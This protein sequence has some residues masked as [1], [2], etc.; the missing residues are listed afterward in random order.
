[1]SALFE[2]AHAAV[3]LSSMYELRGTVT[4]VTGLV[5][6]GTGPSVAVGSHVSIHAGQSVHEAQ[7]VGFRGDRVLLMPFSE[8]QGIS[9]GA[10][11]TANGTSAEVLVSQHLLGRVIDS[12]GRPM[13]GRP[14]PITG[15]LVPL[16]R[17]PP[18]AVTRTRIHEVF[19]LGVRAMNTFL[20]MGTGQ[21]VGI[22][23]GSGVGKSTLLGM[24]A[25]HSQSD[26]N[27]IGLVGERGREVR[28]F[29]ERDLGPEGL[30]R[31][32]VVVATGNEPAL[33]RIRAAFLAT[34][35]A[36][37]FRDKGNKV[38]LMIDSI[39]RLAMA[40][41]EVG[42]A[43]GEPPSTR[44]YTPSVF[45][46]LPK[47]LERAGTC[48]GKGSITGIYTVLVEGDDMNE[49][50]ADATRG[51]LDGHVVLSRKLASKGHFPA[52]DILQS[53]SRVMSDVVS[54]EMKAVA[55]IGR[56]I[57]ATY[58]EAEDL[59]T[60]GAY[61]QGQ[62]PKVDRAVA[63]IDPLTALLRQNALDKC[64]MEDSWR[65]LAQ[66]MASSKQAAPPQQAEK[67]RSI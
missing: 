20:T 53:I 7:V 13:D 22:M 37:Y 62:N 45:A 4:D 6:E 59:I 66:V 63:L 34:A 19:D 14:L 21:R 5:V 51:I 64:T 39:T 65:A 3:N 33:V 12:L 49:P 52:I 26:I 28:E 60:I 40:Q 48:E 23:A 36:E 42:L 67:A 18:N 16:Y 44:G 47:L 30:K 58:Q 41:R 54:D 15:E 11:I 25:R 17:N 24:I 31:S 1:M 8:I 27:V 50:V 10:T 38:V 2:R 43:I 29:I 32:I 57:L 56:E 61:K 35:I 55:N 46:M 9:P